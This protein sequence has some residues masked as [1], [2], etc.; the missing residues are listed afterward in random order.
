MKGN[1]NVWKWIKELRTLSSALANATYGSSLSRDDVK[2]SIFSWWSDLRRNRY[3]GFWNVQFRT[4]ISSRVI[5][6]VPHSYGRF[7]EGWRVRRK[8]LDI[9]CQ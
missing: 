8:R 6:Q 3:G 2:S 1:G 9:T 5:L 7:P 4:V